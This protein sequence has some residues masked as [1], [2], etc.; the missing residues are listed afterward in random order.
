M[1]AGAANHTEVESWHVAEDIKIISLFPHMHLRG[2]AMQFKAV[3]PDGKGKILLDVPAYSFDWQL[4][5]YP[6]EPIVVPAGSKIEITAVW[7]NSEDNP[8]NPDPTRTVGFGLESTDE[9]MFGVFEYV[10]ADGDK[11]TTD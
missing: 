6:K 3:Y 8:N 9:M 10:Y 5:Y 1:P 4:F 11:E 7:D 2:K